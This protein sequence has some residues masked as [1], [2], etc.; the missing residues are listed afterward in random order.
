VTT[1]FRGLR[2]IDIVALTVNNIV[3]AGVF[4]MP[5]ALVAG[6]AG[7]SVG[8]LLLTVALV[9]VMALCTIEVASRY[10]VTGGPM[11]YAGV[12]FGP[13]AGFGV[14]WLMY[15]SRIAA[16]GAIATVMLDYAAGLWPALQTVAA[17]AALITLFV[18]AITAVNIRGVVQGATTTNV[19]TVIKGVPLVWLAAAGMWVGGWSSTPTEAPS[20]LDAL[21]DA[22]LVA[23]FAC[24]GFELAAV[25]A[26]EARDPRRDLPVGM[27]GGVLGA[28]T[29]YLLL[30]FACFELLPDPGASARPLADAAAALVGPAGATV[31]LLTAVTSCAS[32]L[33]GWMVASPRV[34]YALAV[35]G[36]MPHRLV[37]L[38]PL[39]RTPVV[40]ILTSGLLVWAMTVSGTFVY[41]A[42]FS[43]IARLL[44]YASTCGALI[45]LRR[46]A[47][48]APIPVPL[49]R[50]LAV[51]ALGS[52]VAALAFTSGTAVRDVTIALGVGWIG[53]VLTRRWTQMA[54]V[55]V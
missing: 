53:R 55:S 18:A 45:V 8:V 50:T 39:W 28:G 14:G 26:G 13:A 38:H 21:A 3:G 44:T 34:L 37:A 1:L 43:A 46:R 33:S 54:V 6:A 20:S 27:L 15:L 36:D 52:T 2:R 31:V 11:Y 30:L 22:A 9:A 10:D 5:A 12:A 51:I 19:L 23:F 7:W 41:L 25:I 29:L 49:G 16:F 24:M 35:Q 47:G 40:A 32:S 17:R 42:T 48:P 4:T